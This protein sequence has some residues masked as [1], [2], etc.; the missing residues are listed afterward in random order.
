[1]NNGKEVCKRLKEVRRE[2]A[3]ANNIP[4]IQEECKHEGDCMG[5][6]PK[7]EQ[8]VRYLE[9]ELDTRSKLGKAASII[10]IATIAGSMALTSCST[11]EPT[12]GVP[13]LAGE[14]YEE[15]VLEGDPI[16]EMP[17]DS[18]ETNNQNAPVIQI[19]QDE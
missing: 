18:T 5:T 1:M 17:D 12:G 4:L 13:V 8:E 16:Y 2:I 6:C 14:P 19:P 7:C 15:E 9:R 10:G 3:K 11:E